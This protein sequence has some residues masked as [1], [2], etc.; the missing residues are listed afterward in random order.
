M[1]ILNFLICTLTLISLAEAI[2]YNVDV[3]SQLDERIVH[4][5]S[6]RYRGYWLRSSRL[7]GKPAYVSALAE[8][9]TYYTQWS[10][11]KVKSI[12]G[13]IVT[14]EA[15]RFP[16]HYLKAHTSGW[17]GTSHTTYP[18]NKAWAK[19]K[20]RC[21]SKAMENCIFESVRFAGYLFDSHHTRSVRIESYGDSWSRFRILAPD[22][23]DY[24]VTILS[25]ENHSSAASKKTL[26]VSEGI[27]DSTSTENGIT[28][29]V[30]MEIKKAFVT[31]SG[32]ISHSWKQTETKTFEKQTTF[33]YEIIIPPQTK[34][35]VRQ[36]TGEYGPFK[37]KVN[38]FIIDQTDLKTKTAKS[39]T[40]I[41]F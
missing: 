33:S 21:T 16:L 10:Q 19:W 5:E 28:T 34:I 32:S 15:M 13:G 7:L 38:K 12:G 25:T 20:I 27:T 22:A 39:K 1:A 18:D 31:K 30:S 3:S 26:T 2:K 40:S 8:R 9:Q 41:S 29:S 35:E 36:L 37:I 23:K 24:Y 6:L 4:I 17:V 14:M 11:Y